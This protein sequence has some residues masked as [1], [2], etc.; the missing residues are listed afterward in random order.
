MNEEDLRRWD[1]DGM[2]LSGLLPWRLDHRNNGP[3]IQA[4]RIKGN[5]FPDHG[6]QRLAAAQ[7]KRERKLARKGGGA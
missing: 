1:Y 4:P 2:R 6:Q 3:V 7:A 5:D